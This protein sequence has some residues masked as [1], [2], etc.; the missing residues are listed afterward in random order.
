MLW[1]FILRPLG[2]ARVCHIHW[3]LSFHRYTKLF[4][5]RHIKHMVLILHRYSNHALLLFLNSIVGQKNLMNAMQSY[6]RPV[7]A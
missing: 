5:V 2:K 7:F 3:P 4:E 1:I 6:S